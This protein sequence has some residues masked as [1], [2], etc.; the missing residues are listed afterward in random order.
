MFLVYF[1]F[2]YLS[3][4]MRAVTYWCYPSM[5]NLESKF[6][7][8]DSYVLTMSNFRDLANFTPPH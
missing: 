4:L 7:Q 2:F 8:K 3:V 5:L 6:K 1:I